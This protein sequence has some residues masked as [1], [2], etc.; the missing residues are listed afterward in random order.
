MFSKLWGA[1]FWWEPQNITLLSKLFICSCMYSLQA[2]FQKHGLKID[3]GNIDFA[4]IILQKLFNMEG[5]IAKTLLSLEVLL[6]K[7]WKPLVSGN[8]GS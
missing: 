5:G 4:V 7:V 6:Y 8:R 1:A 3:K 2:F